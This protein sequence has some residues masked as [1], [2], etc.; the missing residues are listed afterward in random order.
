ML[1]C[2]PVFYRNDNHAHGG[3]NELTPAVG[4]LD[5]AQHEAAAVDLEDSGQRIVAIAGRQSRCLGAGAV[6]ADP[7]LGCALGAGDHAILGRDIGAIFDHRHHFR[8]QLA[9]FPDFLGRREVRQD[10]QQGEHRV[11]VG[12]KFIIAQGR[13]LNSSVP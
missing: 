4:H 3:R 12:M 8:V 5:A 9:D 7:D 2:Q 1:R 11:Q 6:D 13:L 10:R